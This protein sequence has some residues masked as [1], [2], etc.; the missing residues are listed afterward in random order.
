MSKLYQLKHGHVTVADAIPSRD[1]TDEDILRLAGVTAGTA[2]AEKVLVLA[3][4]KSIGTLGDVGMAALTATTG[5][6]SGA[7]EATAITGSG[8]ITGSQLKAREFA[9]A[10]T[11]SGAVTIPAHSQTF[12]ITK[13]SAPAELTLADPTSPDHDGV[14][15]TFVS[16]TAKAH[17]LDNGAGSGFNGGGAGTDKATFGGAIGDSITIAAYGGKWY[18][19]GSVNVTLG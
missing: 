18:V 17:T 3:A 1:V 6:F 4:D 13:S 9:V 5:G 19:V 15:L 10:A 14:L 12:V 8:I 11:A 16:A 7:I 2:A